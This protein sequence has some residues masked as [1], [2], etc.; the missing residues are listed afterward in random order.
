MLTN[1]DIAAE[2]LLP[3]VKLH[4]SMLAEEAVKVPN[5]HIPSTLLFQHSLPRAALLLSETRLDAI[6]RDWDCVT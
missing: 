6:G 4:C 1:K 2:L 5:R 3:P